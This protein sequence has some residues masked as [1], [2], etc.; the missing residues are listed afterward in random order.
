MSAGTHNRAKIYAV[1]GASGSGKGAR[2]K[3]DFL[4]PNP[5]R[6]LIWDPL[7]EYDEFG[8]VTESLRD[9]A[10]FVNGK[11]AFRAVYR[12][13]PEGKGVEE[14]AMREKFDIFCRIALQL[15]DTTLVVEELAFVTT[16]SWAPGAWKAIT[17]TGRHKGLTV[18]GASQRPAMVDKTFFGLA[19]LVTSGRLLYEADERTMAA[20]LRI[21][22]GMLADMPDLAYVQ[23]DQQTKETRAGV[24]EFPPKILR[25]N[26]ELRGLVDAAQSWQKKLAAEGGAKAAKP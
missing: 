22:P 7:R 6:L 21:P 9:L 25:S 11:R 12:P 18:I 24:V 3:N 17:A 15:P 5:G 8:A 23:R 2:I 1:M 10:A 13:I 14:K 16:P 4:R 19:T 20:V 26:P